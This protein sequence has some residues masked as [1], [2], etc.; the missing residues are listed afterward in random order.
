M[1]SSY[2]DGFRARSVALKTRR[3]A[4]VMR[5][6]TGIFISGISIRSTEKKKRKEKKERKLTWLSIREEFCLEE[7]T[8]LMPLS[9]DAKVGA[10]EQQDGGKEVGIKPLVKKSCLSTWSRVG[11]WAGSGASSC[12]I[13]DR[14][15]RETHWGITYIL[16]AIL[17]YVSANVDVSNGG[18]PTNMAY[19]E[20]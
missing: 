6:R 7:R 19:L 11:R 3:D 13:K 16:C 5:Y 18:W 10:L 17:E 14:A 1:T 9:L 12:R 8:Y 2:L 20:I 15:G 4:K